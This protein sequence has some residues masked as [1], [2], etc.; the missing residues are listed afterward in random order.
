MTEY[1]ETRH[2]RLRT[3]LF[4]TQGA[5]EGDEVLKRQ[6]VDRLLDRVTKT[7][8]S[9]LGS[10][11]DA[12]VNDLIQLS[13]IQ[14]LR[15]A[16]TFRGDSTLDYWADR[17]T[18]QTSAKQFAK[19]TRRRRLW[20]SI[21]HEE[22]VPEEPETIASLS[23]VRARL[24]GHFAELSDGHRVPV[25]MHHLYGYTVDEIAD[26]IGEKEST[27]RGRLRDGLDRLRKRL[28]ADPMLSEWLERS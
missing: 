8:S 24:N 18:L 22:T 7:V 15:S 26:L 16:G 23:E 14:I 4:I 19:R 2:E 9:L 20:E 17:I 10:R 25:V 21:W 1:D 6:L 5:A 11:T 13:L 3:D 27:I 12:E 28:L